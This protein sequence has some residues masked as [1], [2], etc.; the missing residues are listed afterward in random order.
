MEDTPERR[1]YVRDRI[2]YCRNYIPKMMEELGLL[3]EW[4]LNWAD[5]KETIVQQIAD[6]Q[7]VKDRY[8]RLDSRFS[9]PD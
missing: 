5:E 1:E 7:E 2:S 8:E 6:L 4:E 3:L 9:P